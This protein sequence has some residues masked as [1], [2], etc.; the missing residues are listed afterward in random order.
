MTSSLRYLTSPDCHLCERGRD[1]AEKLADEAGIELVELTWTEPWARERIERD[2]VAFPPALYL[3][4]RLLGYGRLSER[5]LRKL[6]M[7]V[8]A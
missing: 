4:D 6:V 7:A 2:A 5:R 1:I 3:E 8:P